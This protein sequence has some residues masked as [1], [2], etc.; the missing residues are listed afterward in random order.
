MNK[1]ILSNLDKRNTAKFFPKSNNLKQLQQFLGLANY[2]KF[3]KDFSK[4]ARPLNKR[5]KKNA[6]F[7]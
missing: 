4:K 5:I 6:E 3:V 2:R 7:Q 1:N